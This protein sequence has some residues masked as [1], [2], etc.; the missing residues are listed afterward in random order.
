MQ[1][2]RSAIDLVF[3]R[4]MIALDGTVRQAREAPEALLERYRSSCASV[5]QRVTVHTAGDARVTGEG[6]EID[7]D[8]QLVLDLGGDQRHILVGGEVVAVEA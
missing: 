1:T 3:K 5:G 4:D 7:D 6:L 2:P 8:G